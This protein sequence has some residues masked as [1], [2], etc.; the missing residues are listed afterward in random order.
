MATLNLTGQNAERTTIA[1][2]LL[3]LKQLL[4]ERKVIWS[5]IPVEKKKKWIKSEK[6]PVMNLAW[7]IYKYLDKNFFGERGELSG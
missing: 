6:D 7:D 3:R 1:P 4:D 5:K 2:K